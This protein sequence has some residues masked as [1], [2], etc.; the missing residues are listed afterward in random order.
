M[1]TSAH[2][3]VASAVLSRRDA[4][5]R[6]RW[7][8]LGALLPDLW[9]F[10]FFAWAGGVQGLPGETIWN[11]TY[12]REPWQTIGAAFNSLPLATLIVA[13]GLA[14]KRTWLTVFGLAMTSHIAL[15]LPLHGDD[16][17]RHF[18]PLTDWRFISPVSYWDPAANGRWG[19]LIELGV[20][21]AGSAILW[22]R[23]PRIW[24][25]SLLGIS[26]AASLVMA[27][28]YWFMPLSAGP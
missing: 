26:V 18:W 21:I 3:I 24:V 2:L 10:V 20:V 13:A 19:N 4:P 5:V 14:A 16:A 17:H 15:D 1:N 28:V 11:E 27:M 8:I 9:I 22:R 25:R 23:F 12:W 6:N 7:I